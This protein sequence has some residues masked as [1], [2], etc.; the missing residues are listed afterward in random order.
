MENSFENQEQSE[1]DKIFLQSPYTNLTPPPG[2]EEKTVRQLK[3]KKLIILTKSWYTNTYWMKVA[4][5]IIALAGMFIAGLF[6]SNRSHSNQHPLAPN[7]MNE[8]LLLLYNPDNF[9]SGGSN[10][11][12]EYGTWLTD[13]RKDG[14][15][16]DGEELNDK[17]WI[18]A[19]RNTAI[20]MSYQPL[21]T[22]QGKPS[23]YFVIRASSEEKALQVASSCPHLK[24]NGIIE[25]RPIQV[26]IN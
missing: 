18:M 3:E 9:I 6:V 16:A 11:V 12:K 20:N 17:G 7:P 2:L 14:L 19:M 21:S 13:L 22:S 8:Y 15:I 24:Y 5:M 10:H 26:H 25:V 23:G 4:A 1:N